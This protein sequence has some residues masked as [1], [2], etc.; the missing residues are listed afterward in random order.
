MLKSSVCENS[1]HKLQVIPASLHELANGKVDVSLE[2]VL[3]KV[4]LPLFPGRPV[5]ALGTGSYGVIF[6]EGL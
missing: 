3:M 6:S 4:Q 2:D 5:G 1:V